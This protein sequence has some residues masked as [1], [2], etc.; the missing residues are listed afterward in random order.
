MRTSA[1]SSKLGFCSRVGKPLLPLV[2]AGLFTAALSSCKKE[3]PPPPPPPV[4]QKPPEPP[5]P[6]PPPPAPAAVS[7]VTLGTA[8]GDDKAISAPKESFGRKDTIYASVATTGTGENTQLKAVWTYRGKKAQMIHEESQTVNLTGEPATH[9][10]HI[11]K[12]SGWPKGD[13]TVEIFLNGAPSAVKNF[14]VK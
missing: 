3:E 11:T 2:A 12:P 5:P 1:S 13:Y 10:F 14:T 6:P 8:V 4:A 7:T 9:E